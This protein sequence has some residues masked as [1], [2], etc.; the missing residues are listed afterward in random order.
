MI[1]NIQP[2]QSWLAFQQCQKA[3]VSARFKP[4]PWG[5]VVLCSA[6]QASTTA[7][8]TMSLKLWSC[9]NVRL[10]CFCRTNRSVIVFDRSSTFLP[11]SPAQEISY[12]WTLTGN[13]CSYTEVSL[14]Y[15]MPIWVCHYQDS[16]AVLISTF[17]IKK[18][19]KS[20]TSNRAKRGPDSV[21]YELIKW[22]G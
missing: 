11:K 19:G 17:C 18:Q 4:R 3:E 21:A 22:L 16:F 6:A 7:Q 5:S 9:C 20:W 13:R 2:E 1:Q 12:S 14:M 8:S 10:T 15:T